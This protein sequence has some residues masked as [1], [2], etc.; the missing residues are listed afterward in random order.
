MLYPTC[1]GINPPPPPP[2]PPS[3]TDWTRLVPPSVLIGHVSSHLRR[4]QTRFEARTGQHPPARRAPPPRAYSSSQPVR[5][6]TQA[7][8]RVI[9]REKR[10][11]TQSLKTTL[12]HPPA[13]RGP[14]SEER[15]ARDR[16]EA[17]R[18]AAHGEGRARAEV[19]HD[20]LAAH[21]AAALAERAA[22]RVLEHCAARKLWELA[23]H[24][25]A[26][27]R[28]PPRPPRSR[29][30]RRSRPQPR[31]RRTGSG[32]AGRGGR[33]PQGGARGT[34]VSPAAS[35]ISQRRRSRR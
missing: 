1:A 19:A 33:T 6:A 25:L 20:K 7:R 24:T 13:A 35:T 28:L 23:N 5:A 26:V 3:R 18:R 15:R 17:D 29:R 34:A 22:R 16:G 9:I 11:S 27:D 10:E 21:L 30:A 8:C 32:S 31:A 12:Y 14:A 2:P 4:H